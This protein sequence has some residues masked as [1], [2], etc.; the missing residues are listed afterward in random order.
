MSKFSL[1]NCKIWEEPKRFYSS[2]L[3]PV[4]KIKI[5][6]LV[7]NVKSGAAYGTYERILLNTLHVKSNVKVFAMQY[8]QMAGWTNMTD[9]IVPYVIHMDEKFNFD[10]T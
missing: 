8:G 10:Q 3:W 2:E 5:I 7:K 6:E 9:Y 4:V 1:I